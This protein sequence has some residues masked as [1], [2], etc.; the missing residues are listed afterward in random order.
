MQLKF[1]LI[2]N[3]I[4]LRLVC[5]KIKSVYRVADKSLARSDLTKK[6]QLKG[7]HFSSNVEVIAA[8]ETWLDGQPY[9]FF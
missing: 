6:K 3:N 8:A 2:H 7:R 9:E 4:S 1:K 5:V